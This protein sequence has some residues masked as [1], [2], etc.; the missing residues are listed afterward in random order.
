MSIKLIASNKKARYNYE[1]LEK[2]EAGIVLQGSEVKS[3]REGNG[4]VKESIHHFRETVRL[5]PDLITA[6][7]DLETAK[8]RLKEIE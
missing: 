7:D 6:R 3:L 2:F 5:R 4:N 8:L 1:I